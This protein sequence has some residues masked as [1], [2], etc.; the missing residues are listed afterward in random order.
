MQVE[1]DA[2]LFDLDGVLANS[3]AAIQR[4]WRLWAHQQQLDFDA[5]MKVSYGTRAA[6]TIRQI[7]PWLDAEEESRRLLEIECNDLDGVVA[8]RG[9]VDLLPQLPTG[10]WA[11]ATSGYRSLAIARLVHVGLPLPTVLVAAEDVH[12]GKPH[13]EPYL[14]A[15]ARLGVDPRRTCVIEDAPAGIAA[16]KAAGASVIGVATTHP[17]QALLQAD[18]LIEDLSDIQMLQGRSISTSRLHIQLR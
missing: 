1:C 15:A 17:R 7:A 8:I 9:A 12:Q 16:G 10:S 4:A 5:V 13:P 6:D 11:V 14:Q 2:I 3:Q 18:H